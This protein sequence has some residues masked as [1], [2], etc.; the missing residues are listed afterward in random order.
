[1]GS[2]NKMLRTMLV[3]FGFTE[4]EFEQPL[5]SFSGGQRAKAA[6]AHVLI[7]DPDY[8]ILDEPTN[9]LDIATVRW[10]ESFIANDKRGY[11]IVSH[12]R[13]FLDRVADRIW[14]LERGN[15]HTYAPISRRRRTRRSWNRRKFA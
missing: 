11:I 14:E 2:R 1:M 12:D 9:H 4:P 13:Y 8:M 15:F 5:R 10:L 7:D 6:L 3:A